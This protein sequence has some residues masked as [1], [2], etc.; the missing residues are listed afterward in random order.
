MVAE[1]EMLA[2]IV[3]SARSRMLQGVEGTFEPTA[4]R[5]KQKSGKR[6]AC[7][8]AGSVAC[9]S[10]Y[11]QK[12]VTNLEQAMGVALLRQSSRGCGSQWELSE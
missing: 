4:L 1:R 12:R 7:V 9:V 6:T 5:P 11:M 3:I 2:A 8:L 10:G